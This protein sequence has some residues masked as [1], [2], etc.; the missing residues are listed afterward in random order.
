VRGIRGGS[1][2]VFSGD[3]KC[4]GLCAYSTVCR[5]G[6]IRSLNKQWPAVEL[7]SI[8]SDSAAAVGANQQ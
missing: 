1:F 8:E 5:I 2:P 7:H 3:K 4:T 6:Q